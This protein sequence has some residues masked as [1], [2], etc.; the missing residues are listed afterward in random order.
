[1]ASKQRQ[2]LHPVADVRTGKPE[3]RLS[4]ISGLD[5]LQDIRSS[6]AMAS[7]MAFSRLGF[8]FR[9]LKRKHFGQFHP[10]VAR[11]VKW[12]RLV[13]MTMTTMVRIHVLDLHSF[14]FVLQQFLRRGATIQIFL[15]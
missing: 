11:V 15:L 8:N 7:W 2:I 5:L 9:L 12:R 13:K 14:Y 6:S 1:M 3:V 4:S 10:R